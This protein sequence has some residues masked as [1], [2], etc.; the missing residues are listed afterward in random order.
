[1]G[2]NF[3]GFFHDVWRASAGAVDGLLGT[4]FVGDY[5]SKNNFQLAFNKFLYDQYVQRETWNR[6][7]TAVQRRAADMKVAGFNPLL[8]AGASASS[9]PVVSTVAP[10][11]ETAR[12]SPLDKISAILTFDKMKADIARTDAD[13]AVSMMQLKNLS[14]TNRILGLQGDKL[15]HDMDIINDTPGMPS[16]TP[17][18]I[19]FIASKYGLARDMFNEWND[20][21]NKLR[22]KG[23][24][25]FK[26]AGFY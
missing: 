23:Y 20:N 22:S 21:Y 19:R 25:V 9:G 6:E 12:Y 11:R 7:D 14:E 1:M 13:T 5:D 10:H 15:Q 24:N 4:N 2:L 8:A 16:D 3:G 17:S 18:I 26:S